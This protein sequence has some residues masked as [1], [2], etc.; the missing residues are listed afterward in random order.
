MQ[1]IRPRLQGEAFLIG[2]GAAHLI[3]RVPAKGAVEELMVRAHS[4]WN[5]HRSPL[6]PPYCTT[7]ITPYQTVSNGADSNQPTPTS[8]EALWEGRPDPGSRCE[9]SHWS[10]PDPRWSCSPGPSGRRAP[11]PC[12]PPWAMMDLA[13]P[14]SPGEG[15]E[16]GV[17]LQ[18]AHQHERDENDLSAGVDGGVIQ[19][20]SHHLEAGTDVVEGCGDRG[21]RRYDIH[22]RHG[23]GQRAANEH[24]Y[25]DGEEAEDGHPHVLGNH[26][27]TDLHWKYGTRVRLPG[28]LVVSVLGEQQDA[29]DLDPSRCRAGGSPHEHYD[30]QVCL[31]EG[32]P[33][34]EVGRHVA[35]CGLN[36]HN[37][38]SSV[39]KSSD[40]FLMWAGEHEAR[41]HRYHTPQE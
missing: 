27:A 5:H 26:S 33:L 10:R 16:N 39:A 35:R 2:V 9:R 41:C 24:R 29:G 6:Y 25:M 28:D 40:D 15:Q 21:H 13:V 17:Q 1:Q 38:E 23:H 12:P 34:V 32:V 4:L 19:R 22:V 36:G 30:H 37:L 20:G 31:G 7:C 8:N 18:S 14:E 11:C 3:I